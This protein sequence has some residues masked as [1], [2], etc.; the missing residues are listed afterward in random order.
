MAKLL[1]DPDPSVRGAAALS[2][3]DLDARRFTSDLIE[4]LHHESDERAALEIAT[5]LAEMGLSE[6]VFELSMQAVFSE[7]PII[8][9]DAKK[10][11]RELGIQRP[12][13]LD[14]AIITMRRIAGKEQRPWGS[15]FTRRVY[16]SYEEFRSQIREW[17]DLEYG[18]NTIVDRLISE[19]LRNAKQIHQ[20]LA[21][22]ESLVQG[23]E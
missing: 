21:E 2:L 9:A 23:E 1:H 4:A 16:L 11:L 6:G 14:D 17:L 5:A 10:R 19:L 3:G 8:Q 22:S 13:V 18:T 15:N 7:N 12:T 20:L